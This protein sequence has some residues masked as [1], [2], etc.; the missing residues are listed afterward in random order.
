MK[1]ELVWLIGGEAGEG[2]MVS[3]RILA[4]TATRAGL[5]IFAYPEYPSLIRGGHNSFQV[6][7]NQEKVGN[8]A[9]KIDLLVALNQETIDLHLPDLNPQ[10]GIIFD[11]QLEAKGP[12]SLFPIPLNELASKAGE[13]IL[14][15]TIALGAS[16]AAMGGDLAHFQKILEEE[17]GSKGEAI[18]KSNCLA[19]QL[20]FEFFNKNF[21]PLDFQFKGSSEN[22]ICLNGN[23]ALALGAIAADCKFY[24]AYPMTPVS[25]IL[26]FLAVHGPK[27]GMMVKQAEDEISVINSVIGAAFAGARAM[28]ATS[29]GGFCL[30]SEAIS[31]AGMTETPI[32]IVEGQ[33]PGPATGLPTWHEQG[34]AAFV[35]NVGHGDFPRIVL[36]PRNIE[37]CFYLSFE[38]FNIAERFR[39]P[40]IILVDKLLCESFASA[41]RFKTDSLQIGRGKLIFQAPSGYKPYEITED[42]VSPRALPGFG[43]TFLTNSDE[44]D[45]FGFSCEESE[46]RVKMMAKRMKKLKFLHKELPEVTLLGDQEPQVTLFSWG[47]SCG[48]AEEVAGAL[49]EKGIKANLLSSPYLRP[50]PS[51]SFLSLSS[52]GKRVSIENNFSS[53]VSTFVRGETG[54]DF[55]LKITKSDGRPFYKEEILEQIEKII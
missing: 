50:F 46:N 55:D 49:R 21:K 29:G 33:R 5:H 53:Q 54:Q 16:L 25:S 6:R 15:N 19:A 44:H 14:R 31:L 35:L 40:V 18:V 37:E 24:C 27:F 45:E 8:P 26:H 52:K 3:G 2:I 23:E 9:S 42:G 51:E 17:F 38:A 22:L 20:G 11:S 12:F 4:K 41:A 48:V 30:M 36:A 47:S 13:K 28:T 32:I 1:K 7:V 43:E 39:N 34:D 10:A